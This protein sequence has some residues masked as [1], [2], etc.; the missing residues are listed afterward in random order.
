M[1]DYDVPIMINKPG[2]GYDQLDVAARQVPGI[3]IYNY[4]SILIPVFLHRANEWPHPK[5]NVLI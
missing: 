2:E 1:N 4:T 3:Y 5:L